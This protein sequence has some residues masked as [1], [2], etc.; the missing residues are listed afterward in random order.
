[1]SGDPPRG[2]RVNL[3][4]TPNACD[5]HSRPAIKCDAW[6]K[7]SSDGQTPH[8]FIINWQRQFPFSAPAIDHQ[9]LKL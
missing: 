4:H 8:A 6:L 1:L 5:E 3:G 9:T 7:K 2:L